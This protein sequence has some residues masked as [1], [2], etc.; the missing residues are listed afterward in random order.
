MTVGR[1]IAFIKML[2]VL[3]L[4]CGPI[5]TVASLACDVALS[6]CQDSTFLAYC[7]YPPRNPEFRATRPSL[8]SVM[9]NYV[10]VR[11]AN[12][13]KMGGITKYYAAAMETASCAV[14]T[15]K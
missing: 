3:V 7:R 2:R 9:G 8:G 4:A 1:V 12:W 11:G 5:E 6:R 15:L 13:I 14:A 10:G